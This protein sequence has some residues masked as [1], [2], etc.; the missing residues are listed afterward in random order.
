M[1][2]EEM[3][4]DFRRQLLGMGI[5]R[6]DEQATLWDAARHCARTMGVPLAGGFAVV[7]AGAGSVTVPVL[8]AVPGYVAG[9]LAGFVLGTGA[10]M[11]VNQGLIDDLKRLLDN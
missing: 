8:G 6:Y 9:M 7:G 5:V 1:D 2:N 11:A 3:T 10:C 4:D